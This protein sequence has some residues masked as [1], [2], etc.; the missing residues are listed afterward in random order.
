MLLLAVLLLAGTGAGAVAAPPPLA[1]AWVGSWATA[2]A[3]PGTPGAPSRSFERVTLRQVVHLSVGGARLRVRLTNVHGRRPLRV[4]ATTVAPRRRG[5]GPSTAG[6]PVPVTFGGSPAVTIAPGTEL[7]SDPVAL[8]VADDSDL[9]IS[10]W[11]PVATGPATQRGTAWATSFVADGDATGDPGAAYRPLDT[12]WYFLDGVDVH[13]RSAGAVVLLGD[14]ITEGCCARS[15]VDTNTRW[16]D[17]LADRLL[18]AEDAREMGV[19]NAGISGNRLLVDGAGQRAPARFDRD[20]LGQTGVRTVVLL[21]GINDIRAARGAT[22]EQV[23]AVYRGV[24]AR[25]KAAGLEVHLGTLTPYGG[26]AGYDRDGERVRQAVN[27]WIRTT[28]S[29]DGVIDLDRALRDP[30]RPTRLLPAYDPGDHLH[31]DR[32]GRAA[33]ARAVDLAALR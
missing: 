19:L 15:S 7:A 8:P 22:A 28:R 30:R 11:L 24:I 23:V 5:G 17:L 21:E 2:V 12:A 32:D 31:P 27:R 4:E 16:S 3:A 33:M 6:P 9:V 25:A 29:V 10:T 13:T 14:S 26:G 1:A 20:V 18:Q